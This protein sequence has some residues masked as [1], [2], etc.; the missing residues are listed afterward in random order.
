MTEGEVVTV[1]CF[2]NH[3]QRMITWY[4]HFTGEFRCIDCGHQLDK[5]KAELILLA[6]LR[7][8][9]HGND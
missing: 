8:L 5:Q 3:C 6:A 1:R 2:C 7:I 4:Q 9:R